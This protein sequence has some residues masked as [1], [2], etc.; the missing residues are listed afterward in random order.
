MKK[1][2]KNFP[3]VAEYASGGGLFKLRSPELTRQNN[4]KLPLDIEVTK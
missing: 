4:F 3:T 2:N 1:F